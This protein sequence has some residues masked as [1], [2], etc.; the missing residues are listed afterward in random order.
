[1]AAQRKTR[2][3][4]F[5]ARTDAQPSNAND[6]IGAQPPIVLPSETSRLSALQLSLLERLKLLHPDSSTSTLRGWLQQGRVTVD[7]RVERDPRKTVSEKQVVELQNRTVVAPL[8][9]GASLSIPILY[10]DPHLVIIEKP[11]GLLSVAAAYEK[12]ECARALLQRQ[13]RGEIL[14]VHRLDRETSGV[15]CFA[16]T[17]EMQE[18]LKDLFAAHD[19]ERQYVAVVEGHLNAAEGTWDC[20]LKEDP[21]SYQVHVCSP[22]KEGGQRAITHYRVLE[23]GPFRSLLELTLETGRKHQIR[24]HCAEAGVP[25][26]GDPR[27]GQEGG[28]LALHAQLLALRHPIFHEMVIVRSDRPRWFSQALHRRPRHS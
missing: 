7:G 28:R 4:K 14:P 25:V 5:T 10:R 11:A 19:L 27:Y 21:V 22:A 15:L 16:R 24:V 13:L 3:P 18:A 1:M 20:W 6:S 17:P 23:E 8:R 12:E 2:P 9:S 26:L